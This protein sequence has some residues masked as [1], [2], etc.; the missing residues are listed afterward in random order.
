MG[1]KGS[2][3]DEGEKQVEIWKIKRV[4]IPYL[5]ISTCAS[6]LMRIPNAFMVVFSYQLLHL[7]TCTLRAAGENILTN[8]TSWRPI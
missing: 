4:C 2:A 1:D 8:N 6:R 7:F 3:P 5:K